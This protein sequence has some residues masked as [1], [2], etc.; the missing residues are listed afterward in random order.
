MEFPA[1]RNHAPG[2][3]VAGERK[4]RDRQA[5]RGCSGNGCS[6][7]KDHAKMLAGRR[8][9]AGP[10]IRIGGSRT[11]RQP[12]DRSGRHDRQLR[13]GAE[14]PGG[15]SSATQASDPGNGRQGPDDCLR[16]CGSG[17]GRQRRRHVFVVEHRPGL[18]FRRTDLRRRFRVRRVPGTHQGSRER[19][20]GWQ[21]DGSRKPGRSHGVGDAKRLGPRAGGRRDCQ[22]CQALAPERYIRGKQGDQWKLLSGDRLG[23]C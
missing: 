15:C 11:G 9:P 2:S 3:A 8:D 23:R 16:R 4:H 12:R 7:R 14:N 17:K 6:P 18:L 13:Y 5:L 20:Q 1:R 19:L 22:G 21:R 10:G